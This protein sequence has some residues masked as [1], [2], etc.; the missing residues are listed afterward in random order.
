MNLETEISLTRNARLLKRELSENMKDI[1]FYDLT[2]DSNEVG[3]SQFADRNSDIS[4]S[5]ESDS[6]D[7]LAKFINSELK[8]N[9]LDELMNSR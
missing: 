2:G 8:D 7:S 1:I 5:K 3:I 9:Q 6:Q 4:L